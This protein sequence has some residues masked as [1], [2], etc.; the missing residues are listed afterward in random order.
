M[1]PAGPMKIRVINPN[2]SVAMTHV[3]HDSALEAAW[4]GVELSTVCPSDGPVCIESH[5]DEALSVPGVL[6]EVIKGE[7]DGVDGYV[8]ACFG[9]PGLQAAR[10][11]AAG[12]VVGIAEAAVKSASYLGRSFSIVTS[13]ERTIGRADDLCALYGVTTACAGVWACGLGPLDLDRNPAAYDL[14]RDRC[15][16]A[17]ELDGSDVIV[18]GC[19]G[20]AAW[21]RKLS[22]D[23]AVP[24]V[25]GVVAGVATVQA[26]ITAGLTTS[27]LREFAPPPAKVFTGQLAHFGGL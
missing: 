22:G 27:T 24:V 25:D 6:T 26:L 18:L 8:I 20:M 4:A 9:D 16:G 12:P 15:A 11:I 1:T 19:A 10:E 17:L 3:I 13:L 7:A 5:Y 21:A 14:V 2:T 23:L